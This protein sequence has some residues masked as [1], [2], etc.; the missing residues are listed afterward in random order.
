MKKVFVALLCLLLT[1]LCACGP[2]A[3]KKESTTTTI[4]ETEPAEI[5]T[6]SSTT[7]KP[8]KSDPYSDA[9]KAYVEKI[10]MYGYGKLENQCYVLYDIDGDGTKELLLGNADEDWGTYLNCV[11]TIQDGVAVKQNQY[12]SPIPE[13]STP[14]PLLF[15]NGTIKG[16]TDLDGPQLS[17]YYRFKNGELKFQIALVDGYGKSSCSYNQNKWDN[18]PLTVEEMKQIKK[19]MEGDGQVVELDWKP[20]AE[21]GR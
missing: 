12:F 19:E 9:I 11:Y 16:V 4:P 10:G 21:Y 8:S 2:A 1:G 17:R 18:I 5:S 3:T 15:Q 20:L 7:I 13:Y 14:P 6:P